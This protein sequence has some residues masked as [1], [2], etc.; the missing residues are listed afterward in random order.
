MSKHTESLIS[1]QQQPRVSPEES[2][3]IE[4][5][6]RRDLSGLKY[7]GTVLIASGALYGNAQAAIETCGAPDLKLSSETAV[8]LWKDCG[9]GAWSVTAASGGTKGTTKFEGRV[10][11]DQ[12][13]SLVAGI[14]LESNDVV[15][16]SDPRAIA[17]KLNVM[18]PW[19]DGFELKHPSG[20]SVCFDVSTSGIPLLVGPNRT[21]VTTPV[22]L[23]TMA[24][25]GATDDNPATEGDPGYNAATDEGTFLWQDADTGAWHLRIAGGGSS[26]YDNNDGSITSD[27]PLASVAGY[28][29]ESND[30]VDTS[31]Q[32]V[33]DYDLIV[34]GVYEDGID[35]SL[36]DGASACLNTGTGDASVYVGAERVAV[37]SP[38]DVRTLGACG[39]APVTP[40]EPQTPSV[41]TTYQVVTPQPLD[42]YA[43][44]RNPGRGLEQAGKLLNDGTFNRNA[45]MDADAEITYIRVPWAN[46]EPNGDNQWNWS[47]L[48]AAIDESVARGKQVGISVISWKPILDSY[49]FQDAVPAWYKNDPRHVRCTDV[50]TPAGC[51]YYLVSS[52]LDCYASDQVCTNR[53]TFNHDDPRFIQ[54][55]VELIEAMRARYDNPQW[56]EKIAYMDIRSIGSWSENH[57]T[58]IS[59]VGRS[60]RWPMPAWS[61]MKAILD[62]HL[63]YRY[64]PQIVNF[65]ND[66]DY[67]EA[68]GPHPW[69]YACSEAQL[70]GQTIGW[71]TDGIEVTL[72]E[73]DQVWSWS[74]AAKECWKTGPVYAEAMNGS[75]LVSADLTEGLS[76]LTN[77]HASGWNNKYSSSYPRDAAYTAEVD[78]WLLD[79]GY[80][81]Q[82]SEAVIPSIAAADEA[83]DV[84]VQLTNVGNAAF[85]RNFYAL[86]V[87]FTPTSYGEDVIVKLP[88]E[89]R[90]VQPGEPAITFAGSGSLPAGEY[91]VSVGLIQDAAFG[92]SFPVKLAQ[93]A[94]S[95]TQESSGWWCEIG[96]TVV[97]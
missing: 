3:P 94:D 75:G 23:S 2:S 96:T 81:L 49:N 65:D 27:Q 14:N 37:S 70:G 16:A 97:E 79:A 12:D 9:T 19:Y 78:Q 69:D 47:D 74:D 31:T 30:V 45:A 83:F 24:A 4:T 22:D 46:L 87:R 39:E 57:T 50:G 26:S 93:R 67:R 53:W 18:A 10:T 90:S 44:L 25:C 66:D 28:S 60:S 86:E 77:W 85:Y 55:Q 40:E 80:R 35:F 38:F 89:L 56:A 71:R 13:A 62:A 92:S 5:A 54:E 36:A 20:A 59:I 48:D 43:E 95:C 88:G 15:D 68:D 52:S 29:L 76:R 61:N 64:I 6:V 21:P 82:V 1:M 34:G 58:G 33:V 41:E 8:L 91:R 51:T 32:E 11:A 73:I 42:A 63:E 7:F 17:Y 84:E 72:W